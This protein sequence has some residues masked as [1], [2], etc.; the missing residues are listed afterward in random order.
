MRILLVKPY[1]VLETIRRVH[2]LIM[3]EPLEFGYL[4]ASVAP[5]HDI[6]VL[7]LRIVRC[8]EQKFVQ[9]LRSYRPDLVGISG[10]THEAAQVKH[11]ARIVR[12]MLPHAK[13]VVGGP[14]ATVLPSD[15]NLDCFDA[16]VRGEGC[17]PF[18]AVTEAAVDGGDFSGIENVLV[19]G[20]NFD[21]ATAELPL[22]PDLA[23][24]PSPRRDLWDP[25]HY[26]CIWP[27]EKHPDWQ[28]IFPAVSLVRT[29]FGCLMECSFCVVPRLCGRKHLARDPEA[30]ASEIASLANEHVYFCD[31][32]TFI[33]TAHA[34][35]LAEAIKKRGVRKRYF[36]WARSTTV[37]RAHD[38]FELWRSIGLDTV[39]L[40]FEAASDEQLKAL[41]KHSSVSENERAHTTLHNIGIAVQAG[42]MVEPDFTNDDFDKLE[43]YIKNMP[44][45]QVTLTVFAPSPGSPAWYSQK[46]TF[47]A[48]P[49]ALHDCMHPLTKTALPLKDFYKRFSSLVWSGSVKSPLRSKANK[50]KPLDIVRV[51]GAAWGYKQVLKRAWRDFPMHMW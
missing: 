20:E 17:A 44:P 38:L 9:R 19:P 13:I 22:Y 39:F 32:E 6:S 21:R 34:S 49:I 14:H 35:H 45:A 33:D 23:S 30:V 37:N 2:H 41:V 16:I 11:L 42:F 12:K 7:D 51:W 26:F 15:Y 25:R 50:I 4:A 24:L 48:D 46:D 8:P 36:A 10:Y 18:R 1:P 40:G 31:D 29:S 5:C 43:L 28:S 47:V 3:L 27:S